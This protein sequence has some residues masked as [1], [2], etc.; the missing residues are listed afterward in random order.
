VFEAKENKFKLYPGPMDVVKEI[1]LA[2][3]ILS[4]PIKLTKITGSDRYELIEGRIKFW[5]WMILFD[6][7]R[8]IP[9]IIIE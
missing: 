9:S 5:A 8:P 4:K 2:G 1:E 7:K 3:G 6:S